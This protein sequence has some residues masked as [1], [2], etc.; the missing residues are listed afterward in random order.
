MF[1]NYL[2]E[3]KNLFTNLGEKFEDAGVNF[4]IV[5]LLS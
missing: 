3:Y 2:K 5:I 4:R 1:R